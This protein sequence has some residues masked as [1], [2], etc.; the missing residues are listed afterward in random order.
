MQNRRQNDDK[1][2]K[3]LSDHIIQ[4]D[5]DPHSL[6][7][8]TIDW[9][10]NNPWASRAHALLSEYV[11]SQTFVAHLVG[12]LVPKPPKPGLK[13]CLAIGI[14]QLLDASISDEQKAKTVHHTVGITKK[15][16]SERESRLVNAVLRKVSRSIGEALERLDSAEDWHIRFSHPPLAGS[17]LDHPTR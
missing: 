15:L 2:W 11:R 6:R 9:D 14:L 13:A 1:I 10:S 17:A 3:K 5:V 16:C 4:F 8:G 7:I 12:K